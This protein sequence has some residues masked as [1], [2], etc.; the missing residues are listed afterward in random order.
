MLQ[1]DDRRRVVAF[2]FGLTT[3]WVV[4]LLTIPNWLFYRAGRSGLGFGVAVGIMLAFTSLAFAIVTMFTRARARHVVGAVAGYVHPNVNF[5][6][7]RSKLMGSLRRYL[8]FL[9]LTYAIIRSGGY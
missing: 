5:R 9:V 4:A 6:C 7:S 2:S 3:L 8:A 1:L